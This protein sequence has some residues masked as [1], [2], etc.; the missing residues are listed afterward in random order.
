[1]TYATRHHCD[2]QGCGEPTTHDFGKYLRVVGLP[3]KVRFLC[4]KHAGYISSRHR[5]GRRI[6]TKAAARARQ[7][8]PV[9]DDEKDI[10]PADKRAEEMVDEAIQNGDY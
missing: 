5:E 3:G 1:M 9:S 6:K 2:V 7:T 10:T 8:F 4:E